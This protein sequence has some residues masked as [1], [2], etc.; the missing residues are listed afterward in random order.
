M[1]TD[2]MHEF[3]DALKRQPSW[4]PP[5]GFARRVSLLASMASRPWPAREPP[6]RSGLLRAVAVGVAAAAAAYVI[7]V[8]MSALVALI[9]QETATTVDGYSRL[10]DLTVR[11]VASRAVF[12]SWLCA[13]VSLAFAASLALRTRA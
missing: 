12:V 5:P 1:P 4:V 6:R 2:E 7:G 10:M 8:L 13:A 3:E 11:A 9:V